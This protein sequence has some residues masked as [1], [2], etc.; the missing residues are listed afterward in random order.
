M[1]GKGDSAGGAHGNMVHMEM[2]PGPRLG[3]LPHHAL[4]ALAR[5]AQ[6]AAG[7]SG[8]HAEARRAVHEEV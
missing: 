1:R 7:L 8:H 2:L 3:L 4:Q 6:Q 5:Q